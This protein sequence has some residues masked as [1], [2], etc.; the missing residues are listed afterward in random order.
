[1]INLRYASL[2]DVPAIVQLLEELGYK[3]EDKLIYDRILKIKERNGQ[4]IV[5]ISESQEV[6][7]CVHVFI[8]LRLA[9]GEIGEVVSLV[10]RN[11]ERGQ[12][13]GKK[14]LDKAQNWIFRKGCYNVR[15]RANAVREQAHLFYQHQGFQEIKSQKVLQKSSS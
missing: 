8:D 4:V 1:M 11:D 12:G 7:G 9:E 3:S 14:L 6:L 5:A 15:V 2:K 10:V 13:I